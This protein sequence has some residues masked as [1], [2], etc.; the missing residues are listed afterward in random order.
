MW[1]RY[2]PTWQVLLL[3]AT[4]SGSATFHLDAKRAD[5]LLSA[6]G[7]AGPGKARL[8]MVV[9]QSRPAD[10]CTLG[11]RQ[12]ESL[13]KQLNIGLFL[14]SILAFVAYAYVVRSCDVRCAPEYAV[15]DP[16]AAFTGPLNN[17]LRT[18]FSVPP[19]SPA[20][21]PADE[22]FFEEAGAGVGVGAG[23]GAGRGRGA[24]TTAEL[25]DEFLFE[26]KA[27]GEAAAAAT[28]E[29]VADEAAAAP[30][31]QQQQAPPEGSEGAAADL[32]GEA[33]EVEQGVDVQPEDK[34]KAPSAPTCTDAEREAALE[35][36]KVARLVQGGWL[37]CLRLCRVCCCLAVPVPCGG[38]ISS[39]GY[40]AHVCPGAGF[41]CTSPSSASCCRPSPGRCGR[42]RHEV[43]KS[44]RNSAL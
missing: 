42:P 35:C 17:L 30:Q 41:C 43:G 27:V 8:R 24:A 25:D 18:D 16:L 21:T 22:F 15:T 1:D 11:V 26:E 31:E 37:G 28:G 19:S 33:V 32:F 9:Y 14:G 20:I 3:D 36:G 4:N 7:L 12:K 44:Q 29:A 5:L 38:S 34:L 23:V 40:D 13:W 10:Q 6:P 2:G 39:V